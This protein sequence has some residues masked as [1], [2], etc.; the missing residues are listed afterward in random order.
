MVHFIS[1]KHGLRDRRLSIRTFTV[2]IIGALLIQSMAS[3]AKPTT[4]TYETELISSL[5]QLVLGEH[6]AAQRH[7]SALT[8]KYPQ[9]RL[10]RLVYADVLAAQA[11]LSNQID[12]YASEKDLII[13]TRLRE[14]LKNR[15]DY[16]LNQ[17]PNRQE[18]VPT[19]PT[20]SYW[21]LSYNRLHT[22]SESS[23]ALWLW[24]ITD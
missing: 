21:D 12:D 23:R 6:V 22:G 2:S 15:W 4:S 14:Q 5:R 9:S 11:G 24:R 19:R 18:L 20:D 10:G 13:I 16:V 8:Q 17:G 3:A 1:I 7:L